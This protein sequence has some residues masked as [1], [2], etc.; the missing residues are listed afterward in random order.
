MVFLLL[1]C[2]VQYLVLGWCVSQRDVEVVRKI[3][4]QLCMAWKPQGGTTVSTSK[5][6]L[7]GLLH[8][9]GVAQSAEHNAHTLGQ[10]RLARCVHERHG[11]TPTRCRCNNKG[12]PHCCCWCVADSGA[13]AAQQA[14]DGGHVLALPAR[15]QALWHQAGV[16]AGLTPGAIGLAPGGRQQG[17]SNHCGQRP[18]QECS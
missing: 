5:E 6:Q 16:Q 11:A 17:S 2:S 1:C 8:A 3:V 13:D 18:E 7:L 9:C 4:E 14:G 12:K 15:V 10:H